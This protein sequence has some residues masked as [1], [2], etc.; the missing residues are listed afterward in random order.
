MSCFYSFPQVACGVLFAST[1]KKA[2]ENVCSIKLRLENRFFT[3]TDKFRRHYRHCVGE[4]LGVGCCCTAFFPWPRLLVAELSTWLPIARSAVVREAFECL[5]YL[6]REAH[7]LNA[8]QAK[9]VELS[10]ANN[11]DSKTVL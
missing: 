6:T 10:S 4:A 5:R 7:S 9:V 1:P 2:T 8:D 3:L 11:E